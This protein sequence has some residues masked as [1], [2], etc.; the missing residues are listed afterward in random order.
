MP[1]ITLQLALQVGLT[2]CQQLRHCAARTCTAKCVNGR[3]TGL[4][5][6]LRSNAFP[7]QCGIVLRCHQHRNGPPTTR[8]GDR[9]T[10]RSI[11]QLA[12][13]VLSFY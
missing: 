12:K 2:V 1:C 3:A 11:Q 9:L 5:S 7:Q 4:G 13:P 6:G 8:N 10:L